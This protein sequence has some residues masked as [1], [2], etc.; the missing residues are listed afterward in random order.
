MKFH[1]RS[2][3]IGIL[4]T[5]ILCGAYYLN[6]PAK[7]TGSID[8]KFLDKE[9]LEKSR[10]G[11]TSLNSVKVKTPEHWQSIVRLQDSFDGNT[12]CSGAFIGKST[13]L[14]AAHC[15]DSESVSD[16]AKTKTMYAVIV[17][18]VTNPLYKYDRIEVVELICE[19][20]PSYAK[21]KPERLGIRSGQDIALCEAKNLKDQSEISLP[22]YEKITF[23]TLNKFPTPG[24]LGG[25]G[26]FKHSLIDDVPFP[27]FRSNSD[28]MRIGNI[29][30]K[31]L[32]KDV[33][34][35]PKSWPQAIDNALYHSASRTDKPALCKGDS[36]G[37]LITGVTE[38]NQI[39]SRLIRGVNSQTSYGSGTVAS[40]FYPLNNSEGFFQKWIDTHPQSQI[41]G[42]TKSKENSKVQCKFVENYF[43]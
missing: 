10:L 9:L 37:P 28:I 15:V 26:C 19:M 6:S 34:S 27:D 20:H 11:I 1:L 31:G 43:Q 38:E 21:S 4:L 3:L 39:G 13:V 40:F 30:L 29:D 25:F 2:F 33:E 5:L 18:S 16:L 41:C 17:R 14:T 23:E 35:K 32:G 7:K 36:G 8:N 22:F 42:M 12:M 24:V